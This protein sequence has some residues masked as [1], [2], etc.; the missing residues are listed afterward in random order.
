MFAFLIL[1]LGKIKCA[2]ISSQEVYGS[3]ADNK[4]QELLEIQGFLAVFLVIMHRS[5]REQFGMLVSSSTCT[6]PHGGQ[7]VSF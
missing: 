4:S 5:W 1:P 7:H 6:D 3:V 2:G